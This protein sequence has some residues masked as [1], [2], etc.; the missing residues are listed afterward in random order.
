M[1]VLLS[2]ARGGRLHRIA[3][4]PLH[5][6]VLSCSPAW[7][8]GVVDLGALRGFLP[9]TGWASYGLLLTSQLLVVG[10]VVANRHLPGTWLVTIGLGLNALVIA[11]NGA[12]PVDPAAIQALGIDGATVTGGKHVLLDDATRLPWL[13]DIWPL[14]PLRSIISVGRRRP[15]CRADPADPRADE[16]ATWR[17]PGRGRQRGRGHGRTS[18]V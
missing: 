7:A 10:W 17:A 15:R 18:G 16:P 12:M 8:A 9:G 6:S 4:A 11:A 2:Y 5:W 1:A 14:P 3:D 13:A